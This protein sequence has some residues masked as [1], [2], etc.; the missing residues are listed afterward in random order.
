MNPEEIT[1]DTLQEEAF[2]ALLAKTLPAPSLQ[3]LPRGLSE[4]IAAATDA[5]PTF[6]ERLTV[7]LRPAPVRFALGGT[8]TAVALCAVFLPRLPKTEPTKPIKV[9]ITAPTPEPIHNVVP[10]STPSPAP[11]R[12]TAPD[13][14]VAPSPAPEVIAPTPSPVAPVKRLAVASL[15]EKA[16]IGF[17]PSQVSKSVAPI[18]ELSHSQGAQGVAHISVGGRTVATKSELES[19]PTPASA[20]VQPTTQVA[21]VPR[22]ETTLVSGDIDDDKPEVSVGKPFNPLLVLTKE[23]KAQMEKERKIPSLSGAISGSESVA[24]SSS[25]LGLLSAPVR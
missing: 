22:I 7:S 23:E 16:Q 17:E 6:W 12:M 25:N 9:A 11:E 15:K 1:T 13:A 14:I 21:R 24:R 20:A 4:R 3:P 18:P 10:T 8:V 2:A 5:R 19:T